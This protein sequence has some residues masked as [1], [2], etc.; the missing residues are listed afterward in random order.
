MGDSSIVRMDDRGRITLPAEVRKFIGG[1]VFKIE[2]TGRD[3]IVLRVVRGKE[4]VI[5]NIEKIRLKGD[6]TRRTVD[7]SLVKHRVGGVKV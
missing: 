4:E 1:K 7:A 3:E 2:V 5:E 6:A